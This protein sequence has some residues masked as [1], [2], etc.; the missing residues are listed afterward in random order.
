MTTWVLLGFIMVV[1]SHWF[2]RE[3]ERAWLR[4]TGAAVIGI[5]VARWMAQQGKRRVNQQGQ[6]LRTPTLRIK[7]EDVDEMQRRF[8]TH[9]G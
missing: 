3:D 9:D 4:D 5:A 8:F 7:K 6:Q 1:G 2:V